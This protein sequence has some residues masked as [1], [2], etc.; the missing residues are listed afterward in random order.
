MLFAWVLEIPWDPI[1]R[2]EAHRPPPGGGKAG[3]KKGLFLNST[4]IVIIPEKT[5]FLGNA[6]LYGVILSEAQ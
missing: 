4:N 3:I 6:F 2:S 5:T 1:G